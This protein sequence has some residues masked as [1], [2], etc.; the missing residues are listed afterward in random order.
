MFETAV[1]WRSKSPSSRA[2]S[3]AACVSRP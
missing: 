3:M 1:L 2:R